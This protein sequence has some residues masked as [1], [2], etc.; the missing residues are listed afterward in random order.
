[1]LFLQNGGGDRRGLYMENLQIR[2]RR[3]FGQNQLS[4]KDPGG[5]DESIDLSLDR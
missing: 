4:P 2:S 1:M 3:T 5:M